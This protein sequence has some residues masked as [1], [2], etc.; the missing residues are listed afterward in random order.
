M[1]YRTTFA[2]TDAM[3][4]TGNLDL[5]RTLER[6]MRRANLP[7]A[8]SQGFNP[9]PKLT[10][11]D[12]LPLGYTSGDEIA[13]FWLDEDLPPEAITPALEKAAPPGIEFLSLEV[14]D[15]QAAK[16][17]NTLAS[18]VY[19]A[20]LF[21]PLE[22]ME[23][24]VADLLAAPELPRQKTRKGKVRHYDLRALILDIQPLPG[25]QAGHQRLEMRL[26]AREGA[27]TRPNEIL[28]ELGADPLETRVHRTALVFAE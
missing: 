16:L 11:A 15:P 9:R 27:T 19:Q 1:R 23:N 4:F 6:T 26:Q 7:L 25:D 10:L 22:E 2:K 14:I 18:A 21:E 3:R 5:H 20:T 8:Y 17:Q 24:K 28:T 12:A 13:D